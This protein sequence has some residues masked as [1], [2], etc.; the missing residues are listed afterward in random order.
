MCHS[1][2]ARADEQPLGHFRIGKHVV[3]MELIT[4]EQRVGLSKSTQ[5]QSQFK[6]GTVA[7]LARAQE[8]LQD[9]ACAIRGAK[10]EVTAENCP[11]DLLARVENTAYRMKDLIVAIDPAFNV[12]DLRES[13]CA[14]NPTP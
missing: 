3:R 6:N 2:R 12:D 1:D 5:A 11:G 7:A 4:N 10:W 8:D 9:A 14:I 13:P